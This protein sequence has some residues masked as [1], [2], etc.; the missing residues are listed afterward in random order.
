MASQIALREAAKGGE[1]LS[2]EGFT[3]WADGGMASISRVEHWLQA[4]SHAEG[5]ARVH[6]GGNASGVAALEH[7][8]S[9]AAVGHVVA[10]LQRGYVPIRS[11][12]FSESQ[13]E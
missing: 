6:A 4:L 11:S 10:P 8:E 3:R 9:V 12:E 1:S 2:G 5:A 13:M 7:R